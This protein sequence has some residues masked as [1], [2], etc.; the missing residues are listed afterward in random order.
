MNLG[1]RRSCRRVVGELATQAGERGGEDV[2]VVEGER[3]EFAD[4]EPFR[5]GG[6]GSAGDDA[7]AGI[8]LHGSEGLVLLQED[9]MQTGLL[10]QLAAGGV[11]ERFLDADKAARQ[12]PLVFEGR[13]AAPDE[14]DLQFTAIEAEGHAIKIEG[15][16]RVL[17][18]VS[19]TPFSV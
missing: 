16:V 5:L 12:R 6:I 13:K 9:L 1:E 2:G 19:Y 4:G 17:V 18:S 8:A 11:I 10:L 15:G 3:R 7:L 14:Q